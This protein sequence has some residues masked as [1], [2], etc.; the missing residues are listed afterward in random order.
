M[1]QKRRKAWV[2]MAALAVA[3]AGASGCNAGPTA[4]AKDAAAKAQDP[5]AIWFDNTLVSKHASG[6]V[7][8]IHF[9]ADRTIQIYEEG[10]LVFSGVYV[11]HPEGDK[12]CFSVDTPAGAAPR[13]PATASGEVP[14]QFCKAARTSAK[15]GDSWPD[16]SPD[17][18]AEQQFVV[19]GRTKGEPAKPK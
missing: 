18:E 7:S 17:G 16:T 15:V 4:P 8:N 11:Y 9:N 3:A 19:A 2:L 5:M 12:L 14:G 6:K 10:V 1:A 13:D